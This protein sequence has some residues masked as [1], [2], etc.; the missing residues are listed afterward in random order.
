MNIRRSGVVV[1]YGKS[2]VEPE[3]FFYKN[4]PQNKKNIPPNFQPVL[5]LA[6][7]NDQKTYSFKDIQDILLD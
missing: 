4:Y 2:L 5:R 7:S 6:F 3:F 1:V